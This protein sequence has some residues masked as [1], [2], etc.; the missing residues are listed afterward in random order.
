MTIKCLAGLNIVSHYR[1]T[2]VLTRG[3]VVA[4]QLRVEAFRFKRLNRQ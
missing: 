3:N 2:P 4:G 1:F